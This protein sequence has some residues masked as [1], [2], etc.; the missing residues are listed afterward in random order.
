MAMTLYYRE[1]HD[2]ELLSQAESILQE[3][4]RRR[5]VEVNVPCGE[6]ATEPHWIRCSLDSATRADGRLSIVVDRQFE[7]PLAK[8]PERS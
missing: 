5:L 2:R 1:L 4:T 3:L 8:W 7:R 6:D